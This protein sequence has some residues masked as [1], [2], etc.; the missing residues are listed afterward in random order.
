[1]TNRRRSGHP[2]HSDREQ[3]KQSEKRRRKALI[4][5]TPCSPLEDRDMA[6]I[7]NLGAPFLEETFNKYSGVPCVKLYQMVQLPD[8]RQTKRQLQ[9]WAT[10]EEAQKACPM[11]EVKGR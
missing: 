10:L 4:E 8:G 2:W 6:V 5:E 11:V 1:V 3:A 9:Q 7:K